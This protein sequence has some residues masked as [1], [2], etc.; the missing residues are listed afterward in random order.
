MKSA[1]I[2]RSFIEFFA[3][4]DHREVGSSSLVP[5]GDP[6]LLFTNA[7]MVQFKRVFQG[8][9]HRDYRRAVTVQKC[10]RAGGKHNDLEQVGHTARHH[11]FFE[12]LGNFSF[13]DY[14]KQDAIAFAWEW[15]TSS[16]YLG[17]A[18]DRLYVTVHHAD[19]EARE[20]WH[21]V[22]GMPESRIFGLGD[23]DNFWQMGDTGPCGPCSEIYVDLRRAGG[24][25]GGRAEQPSGPPSLPQFLGLAESGEL[26]EIWNLVFMQFDQAADGSRSPLPAPSVDTGA[27]LERIAAVMQEA[28]SN[29][30][31]D[32]F[33]PI[34]LRAEEIVGRPYDRGPAGA[35]YRV[36]A[37]HARA[38]AFLLAD[39]VY[40]SSDGRGYVLRRIL[41][42]AVRHAYLLGRSEPTLEHLTRTVVDSLGDVYPELVK[43]R[44][45][46]AQVTRA[47][48]ER[49]LETIEGGLERL[50]QILQGSGGVVSGEEAFKLY[51]TYGFPLDL[52]QVIA[53]ERG[54]TVDA[55]RFERAL[56]EQR[57][58]S[59]TAGRRAGGPAVRAARGAGSWV[60]V[61]PRKR[62][63]F[64]GYDTTR[65]D[66]DI[67]AF[68][69]ADDRLELVLHENPFYAESGGQ[70]SDTG[71]VRGQGW[72]LP[73]E[74]VHKDNGRQVVSGPSP[75]SFEAT[76][77]SAE[78]AEQRRRDIERNHTATH[79][80]H[81]ALRHVLGDHVRQ[82]GSVV[83]PER[84]RFDFSHH[85]PVTDEQLRAIE[86]EVNRGIWRNVDILTYE[87]PYRE[88]L[89]QGAMALFGEKYGDRVRVVDIPDLSLELCGG[90]HVRST[91]QIGL[92]H[93]AHE[94]GV[95]AGVR[96]IEA[97]T[98]PG[99]YELVRRLDERLETVA[100]LLKA[101]PEHLARRVEG[102]LE[103]Q[104][105][106][107]RQIEDLLRRGSGEWGVGS[108]TVQVGDV[109]LIVDDAPITDRGQVGWL[110]DVFREQQKRAIKVLFTGG[111][112][113]GVHV[114]V[115][116]DLVSRGVKAGDLVRQIAALSG[117]SGGGRP[118]F[119]SGGIGR[120]G[121]LEET[122]RR[123]AEIV[124]TALG[125][126]G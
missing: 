31:T 109:T 121:T 102:L 3:Q 105:K 111:E 85:A 72:D 108:G 64:V 5:Q 90:T 10:V 122:R 103:E 55:A 106:L 6:T 89:A 120:A 67:L 48:E 23:E 74:E 65:A 27:G 118:H 124:R 2:R 61:T 62:Q 75:G 60:R 4:R 26:L 21:R 100:A 93:F 45:H 110:M 9:E 47:E 69:E 73:V 37:D 53:G 46:I 50:D 13:G 86:E 30:H 126:S 95:A 91:G 40:P 20:L 99:A 42:R 84:L 94:T 113:P 7:G 114:A 112:R 117:G 44:E 49:F 107:E 68:R 58:R 76:P 35:G 125:V 88:A 70:V 71:I 97:V 22:T 29:F 57:E 17:I 83:A 51:D 79:L 92:F 81:A 123:V 43:K 36:L 11:T 28:D 63:R 25:A 54:W 8:L 115:T 78:V 96:R 32:L 87:L 1:R 15:V 82:A 59:R 34:I 80:V 33:L 12:M 66:T 24:P 14:F 101:S 116:D 19:D 52:T 39:G 16:E 38:V 18:P 56:A 104:R 41:R 77:V 98:G 119:A